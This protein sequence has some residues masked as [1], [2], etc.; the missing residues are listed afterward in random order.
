MN[1]A[2]FMVYY[3]HYFAALN[4]SEESLLRCANASQ[5]PLSIIWVQHKLTETIP[6]AQSN[7]LFLDKLALIQFLY[8][9]QLIGWF[10]AFNAILFSLEGTLENAYLSLDYN[11]KCVAL[12]ALFE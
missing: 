8:S 10:F 11:P 4:E 1:S 6:C 12:V 5:P 9:F 7:D 2:V 3:V